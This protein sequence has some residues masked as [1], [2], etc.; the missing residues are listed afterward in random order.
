MRP[1]IL[2]GEAILP[3]NEERE[4]LLSLIDKSLEWMTIEREVF[5]DKECDNTLK[6]M[7]D[8]RHRYRTLMPETTRVHLRK[9]IVLHSLLISSA[10]NTSELLYSSLRSSLR[11]EYQEAEL[12]GENWEDMPDA[13]RA[14]IDDLVSAL[15]DLDGEAPQ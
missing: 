6:A 2:H 11:N 1:E 3:T 7:I 10:G 12:F 9:M 14:A 5:D 4:S 13:W 8:V 15:G